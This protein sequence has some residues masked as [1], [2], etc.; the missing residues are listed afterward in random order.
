MK[1]Y[2]KISRKSIL[3]NEHVQ[4][5]HDK[6]VLPN[7][8][9]YDYFLTYNKNKKSVFILP[10][11][12]NGKILILREYRYPLNKVVY[13]PVAGK[14]DDGE[15]IKKAARRELKEE[16]GYSAKSMIP[17]G[18]FYASPAN[19]NTIFYAFLAVGL[20]DGE[21]NFDK[22]EVIHPIWVTISK[23]ERMVKEGLIMDPYLLGLY[24][25]FKLK[26]KK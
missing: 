1:N 24:L 9:L 10:M 22:T 26:Y 13:G 23:F 25:L 18:K 16:T 15:P 3:I 6:V 11:D 7:G 4:L 14:V 5:Y 19:S 20:K 8:E 17:L 12:K 2:K 21:C